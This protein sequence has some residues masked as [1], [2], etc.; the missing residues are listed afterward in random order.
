MDDNR[1]CPGIRCEGESNTCYQ[2]CNHQS[3][4]LNSYIT[5]SVGK[6]LCR[7]IV[8]RTVY[9]ITLSC[10]PTLFHS[11]IPTLFHSAIPTWC[12]IFMFFITCNVYTLAQIWPLHC[13][14]NCLTSNSTI[15]MQPL[16]VMFITCDGLQAPTV[17]GIPL[18]FV[19]EDYSYGGI[20][21]T[22]LDT[23]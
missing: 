10:F 22:G 14:I 17:M 2:E 15:K 21:C 8:Y 11:A 18:I 12:Y 4:I 13:T 23:L 16:I 6:D 7:G 19:G 3:R 5:C 20:L 1:V 9:A